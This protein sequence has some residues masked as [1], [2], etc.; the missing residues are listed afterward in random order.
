[1]EASSF[2]RKNVG[3][4]MNNFMNLQ[5]GLYPQLLYTFDVD[6]R[7]HHEEYPDATKQFESFLS[8]VKS[9]DIDL[10]DGEET[11]N[12]AETIDEED[13]HDSDYHLSDEDDDFQ[14]VIIVNKNVKKR[15]RPKIPPGSINVPSSST[16][17]A[18]H[19]VDT[20]SDYVDSN[21]L[22]E[23]VESD[24]NEDMVQEK[25]TFEEYNEAKH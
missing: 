2:L 22:S 23:E 4:S 9:K 5:N 14:E 17:V 7:D 20:E 3:S 13:F 1:M 16:I 15:G 19:V 10:N 25:V 18:P 6:Q 11:D 8:R 21:E 12:V 24:K